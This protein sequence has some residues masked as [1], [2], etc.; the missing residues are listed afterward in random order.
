MCHKKYSKHQG[1]DVILKKLNLCR[2][3]LLVFLVLYFNFCH[4]QS[5]SIFIGCDMSKLDNFL[6]ISRKVVAFK[7]QNIIPFG[8]HDQQLPSV[9]GSQNI[10]APCSKFGNV[11]VSS[12]KFNPIFPIGRV[13]NLS[14][15]VATK[16][17]RSIG[18]NIDKNSVL[19][20]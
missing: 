11:F 16:Q 12:S 18:S 9:G 20:F 8:G 6:R 19:E 17:M 10:T 14:I 5:K 3:W 2:R 7:S 13:R 1:R 15:H 4:D